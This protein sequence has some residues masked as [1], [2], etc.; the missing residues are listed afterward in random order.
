MVLALPGWALIREVLRDRGKKISEEGRKAGRGPR[1]AV[2][3]CGDG[4]REFGYQDERTD[5]ESSERDGASGAGQVVLVG[6]T[7]PLDQAVGT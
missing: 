1:G 6:A 3:L 4:G 5:L 7:D 2:A